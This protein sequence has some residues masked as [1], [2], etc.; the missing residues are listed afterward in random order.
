[1]FLVV[2]IISANKAI[3]YSMTVLV[4]HSTF[5]LGILIQVAPSHSCIMK[6]EDGATEW[7]LDVNTKNKQWV[8]V[9]KGIDYMN[10]KNIHR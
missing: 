5:V 1:M 7:D 4:T 6:N 3:V 2:A 9:S 8:Y 10:C